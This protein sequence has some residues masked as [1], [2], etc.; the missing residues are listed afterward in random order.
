MTSVKVAVRV[1]P[2]NTRERTR[3]AK[4]IIHMNPLDQTTFI[5]NPQDQTVKHYKYDYSYWSCDESSDGY[6]QPTFVTQERVYQD[7]GIE[8][9]DHAFEGYN[10]C[11]FAYGQTGRIDFEMF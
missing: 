10:V 3:Q 8:M 4:C 7:L 5:R 9:L 1:R 11:I 2:F 6:P